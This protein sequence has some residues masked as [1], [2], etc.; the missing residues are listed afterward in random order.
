MASSRAG[1][2]ATRRHSPTTSDDT[3]ELLTRAQHGE[4]G[5]LDALLGRLSPALERWARGRLPAWARERSETRDLVQ[6]TLIGGLSH[7]GRFESRRVGALHAYF[8][9]AILNRIRDE[10]R[11]ARRFPRH[12]MLDPALAARDASPL[13]QTIGRE[14]LERYEAALSRLRPSDRE[15]IIGRVELGY[16]F[17]ELALALGKPSAEAARAAVTRA[18]LR[19]G[20]EMRRAT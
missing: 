16:S 9:Q 19:L 6:D 8:R 11:R 2:R 14:A 13:E 7:L 17:T 12:Q 20:A 3:T 5:A 4:D 18:I 1:V 10:V 15:A